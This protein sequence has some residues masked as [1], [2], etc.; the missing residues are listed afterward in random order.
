MGKQSLFTEEEY[1]EWTQRNVR[2]EDNVVV[3]TPDKLASLMKGLLIHIDV[4]EEFEC[5]VRFAL[6]DEATNG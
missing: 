2:Y 3:I 5:V 1:R 4:H 6:T